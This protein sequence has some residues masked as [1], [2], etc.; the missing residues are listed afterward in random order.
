MVRSKDGADF[1]LGGNPVQRP[2]IFGDLGKMLR[3]Q[4]VKPFLQTCPI[5]VAADRKSGEK[6]LVHPE[7]LPRLR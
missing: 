6:S 4:P 3:E 7:V 1:T 2:N 5:C